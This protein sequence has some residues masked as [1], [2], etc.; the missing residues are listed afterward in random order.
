[1]LDEGLGDEGFDFSLEGLD[2]P[3][4]DDD[5]E[6]GE[7]EYE[8]GGVG[9][10]RDD[11]GRSGVAGFVEDHRSAE[12]IAFHRDQWKLLRMEACE[13]P[14]VAMFRMVAVS[15][16]DPVTKYSIGQFLR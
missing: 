3:E 14:I 1:M 11:G 4:R 2:M 8:M 13:E 6:E 5:D 7:G 10:G 9:R 12:E 15:N 16:E